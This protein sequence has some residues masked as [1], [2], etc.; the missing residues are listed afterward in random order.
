M[1]VYEALKAADTPV[2]RVRR[3]AACGAASYVEYNPEEGRHR[4]KGFFCG[5]RFCRPCSTARSARGRRAVL[6]VA[7]GVFLRFVTLTLRANSDPLDVSLSRLLKSF[8]N[9]RSAK[10]WKDNVK[11]GVA[12][13]E[14]KRGRGSGLWHVHLHALIH[15]RRVDQADLSY[16]WLR[17][18]GDSFRVD[19]RAVREK[20]KGAAYVCKYLGKGFDQ[21]VLASPED[22]RECVIALGGRRLLIPFGDW[23]GRFGKPDAEP[24]QGW[25]LVGGLHSIIAAADAGQAWAQGVL[26]SLRR[27]REGGLVVE[28]EPDIDVGF[29]PSD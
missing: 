23:F 24:Q 25:K 11:G 6:A 27:A 17:A 26:L 7:E 2:N 15:G 4:V 18:T 13:V 16:A 28:Q 9:L 19:I 8:A 10:I 29:G 20:E 1:R 21:S 3:F 5:D 12:V 14:I 22:L